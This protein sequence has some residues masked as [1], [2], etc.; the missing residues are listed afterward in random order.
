[1]SY[2]GMSK[3][4]YADRKAPD[5]GFACGWRKVRKGGRVKCG[6]AWYAAKELEVI[7][8]E[9]VHV[10]IGEYWGSYIVV[11]RGAVSCMGFFCTANET[12]KHTRGDER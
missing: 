11:Q 6:G 12:T 8:G 10:Q 3:R 4:L 9:L 2:F 5:G 7:P 1:M